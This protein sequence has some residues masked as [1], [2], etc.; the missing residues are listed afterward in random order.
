MI[1]LNDA[2]ALAQKIKNFLLPYCVRIEIAGSVRREKPQ[3]KDLEIVAIPKLI[4]SADLF[5]EGTEY[6]ALESVPIKN[7]G[8]VA[9]NGSRYKQIDLGGFMLDLFIVIPPAQWGIIFAIRTGP[10]DFS[11]WLV[12]SERHGGAMPYFAK[13]ENGGVYSGGRLI[14][15]PEEKDFFDFLKIDCLLPGQRHAPANFKINT[16]PR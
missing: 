1:D 7:I 11:H 16:E 4:P 5:G 12:T 10:A 14:E 2:I 9:K 15:M 6:S 8:K 3:V 13:C